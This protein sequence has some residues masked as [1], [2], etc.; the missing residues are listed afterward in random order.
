M[1]VTRW[2]L[3][4]EAADGRLLEP[5]GR[6]MRLG[7]TVTVGRDGDLRVGVVVADLGISR[8][9]LVVRASRDGWDVEI[10][11]RNGAVLHAWGQSPMP[12]E[13]RF[14]VQWPLAAIRLLGDDRHEHWVL[15]EAPELAQRED[16]P[17]GTAASDTTELNDKPLPLTQPQIEALR[18]MFA[19]MLCWPPMALAQPRQL[20]QVARELGITTEAVQ[21]RLRAARAKA[22]RL[23]LSRQLE[24]PDPEYLYVL[25]RTGYLT[26]D[27]DAMRRR[28]VDAS[29]V[30]SDT[31]DEATGA[32]NAAAAE[33]LSP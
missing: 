7:E 23:G 29:F 6:P 22:Y 16:G 31:A 11:N 3:T 28:L 9:A 15:L 25:V 5:F 14:S 32:H 30:P 24:L 10:G 17:T 1:D 4:Q 8:E 19:D 20:K 33:H 2:V 27:P 21:Q 13:G 12:V 26:P 18:S